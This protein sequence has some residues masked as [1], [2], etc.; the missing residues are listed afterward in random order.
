MLIP[1]AVVNHT[2]C[3]AV[4]IRVDL[5]R[6]VHWVKRAFDNLVVQDTKTKELIHALIT[7]KI[8]ATKGADII[9]GKGNGVVMQDI[10]G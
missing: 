2:N 9:K 3:E 1:Y 10:H 8:L 5:I 4:N 6:D 7:T